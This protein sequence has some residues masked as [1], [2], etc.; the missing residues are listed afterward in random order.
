MNTSYDTRLKASTQKVEGLKANVTDL[1]QQHQCKHEANEQLQSELNA[2][3]QNVEDLT[4]SVHAKEV[5][6]NTLQSTIVAHEK[7]CDSITA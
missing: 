2:S 1:E 3:Q 5:E 4:A 6:I 7:E